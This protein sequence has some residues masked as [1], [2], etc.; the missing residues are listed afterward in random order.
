MGKIKLSSPVQ[1][2]IVSFLAMA[3]A[4][5]TL[6]YSAYHACYELLAKNLGLRA[7][8]TAQVAAQLVQ[9]DRQLIVEMQG[10]DIQSSRR[11]PA[12]LAFKKQMNSLL[13]QQDIKY[14]YVETKLQG[15]QIRYF[16]TP[17]EERVFG[18][19]PGT[20]LEYFYVFTSEDESSY[21]NRDRY[22]V[23]DRL[24]QRAYAERKPVYGEP[25]KSKWGELIT[26][27]AP[28]FDRDGHF[29]G[30][31]G[32]DI[33]GQEFARSVLYVRNIII[34][35][36]GIIVILGGFFLYRAVRILSKPMY[37]DE[38]TRLYNRQYMKARL[39]EEVNRAK[40]YGR[41]LSVLMLDLDF[42]KNINDCYGHQAGDLV[43]RNIS[44]LLLLNL[45]EEDIAC[46]YGG[47]EMVIILPETDLPEAAVVAERLRQSIERMEF[48]LPGKEKPVQITVSIGV[49]Q[50]N[51]ED[52]PD[53]LLQRADEGLYL[54]KRRGR[55]RYDFCQ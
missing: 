39:E 25:L 7:Q 41:P 36:F 51:R 47:E 28:L 14:I 10:L 30:L 9:V 13:Q 3:V 54:A 50:M 26:G 42:F 35:S 12:A 17:E 40:R 11:H 6:G 1:I 33:S 37:L 21:T 4:L 2:F 32:V 48:I 34:L 44:Q 15:S 46:R 45:R 8:V 29:I 49:A 52:T 18:Q 19:P 20:P 43:L 53:M 22:D 24:R 31:L 38:L 16:V 55:N 27:Y 23:A 5:A